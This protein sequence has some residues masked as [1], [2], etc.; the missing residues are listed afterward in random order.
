MAASGVVS[1]QIIARSGY[2]VC[3][4]YVVL[5]LFSRGGGSTNLWWMGGPSYVLVFHWV[6]S[7]CGVTLLI[8][9]W[10][11]GVPGELFPGAPFLGRTLVL[12]GGGVV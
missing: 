5:C 8:S 9:F 12:G 3:Y 7:L 11:F 2:V 10:G 1:R 6:T 4:V